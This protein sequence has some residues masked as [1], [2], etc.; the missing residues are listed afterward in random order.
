MIVTVSSCSAV[1]RSALSCCEPVDLYDDPRRQRQPIIYA[2]LQYIIQAA[3]H[4]EL[5]EH[6]DEFS[7]SSLIYHVH[8]GQEN[9]I[10]LNLP[11]A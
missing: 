11:F 3:E 1:W 5:R 4:T 7:S 8:K 10:Q 2:I 9:K 6:Y